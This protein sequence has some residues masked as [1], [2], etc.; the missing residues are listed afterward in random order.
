MAKA[1]LS[2]DPRC[3]HT[4]MFW[5]PGCDH[6]HGVPV[7]PSQRGIKWEWNGSLD[8]PTLSPSLL[9]RYV[10]GES[11]P[12]WAPMVCHSFIRDGRIEFL[13]DCT[14]KLAGQTV[15]LPDWETAHLG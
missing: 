4:L 12:E 3:V 6:P 1:A 7:T 2:N 5:C 9:I 10:D 11:R 14:H 13:S 8:T 15:D